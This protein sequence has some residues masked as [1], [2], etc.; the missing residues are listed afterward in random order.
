MNTDV[1][2]QIRSRLQPTQTVVKHI[3][4]IINTEETTTTITGKKEEDELK[5][6]GYSH[7]LTVSLEIC[8]RINNLLSMILIGL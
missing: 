2:N 1:L 3:G 8:Y 5:D 7:L 6:Y 4:S